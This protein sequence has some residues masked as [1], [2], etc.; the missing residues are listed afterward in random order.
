MATHT[1]K[2]GEHLSGIAAQYGFGDYKSVWNDPGNA[3]LRSQRPDPHVLYPGDVVT[4]PDKKVKH[5][6]RPTGKSHQ[7]KTARQPLMLRLVLRDFDNLPLANTDCEL[8]IEGEKKPLKT[9][10]NGRLETPVPATAE[11]GVLRVPAL[12]MELEVKIGHLDPHDKDSGWIGR[13]K[14][15]GYHSGSATDPDDLRLRYAVEEFQCDNKLPVTGKLDAAT[16]SKLKEI[17]GG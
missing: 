1:V 11:K 10:A 6:T 12:E 8:E 13:L 5:E 14:N 7:F 16:S 4:I 17:H 3:S 15:L 2:Q 9:D